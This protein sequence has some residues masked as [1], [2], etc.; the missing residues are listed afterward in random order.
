MKRYLVLIIVVLMGLYLV[1]APG[2]KMT[3]VFI[4]PGITKTIQGGLK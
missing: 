2:K 1:F 3:D 4:T